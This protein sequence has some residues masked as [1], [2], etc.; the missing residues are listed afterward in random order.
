MTTQPI[1]R[2]SLQPRI[3]GITK[4]IAQL[5]TFAALPPETFAHDE[6]VERAHYHLR[7]ALEGVLN[8]T[9]HI[10]SRIPGARATEYKA[11]V[12]ELGEQGIVDRSFAEHALI[13][14][15]GYRNRLTHGYAAIDAAELQ[16]I[17]RDKLD[18]IE[19]FLSSIRAL[20]EHPERFDLT[21]Q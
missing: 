3:D 21:L 12:R 16:S 11:M 19:R 17:C 13:P 6:V 20:L 5:R 2:A 8:I 1:L 14:M 10:L 7:L 15:A 4:N 9:A 18:D